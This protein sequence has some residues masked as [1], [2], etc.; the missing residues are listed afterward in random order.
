M[1]EKR[2]NRS[3]ENRNSQERPKSWAPPASLPE[4]KKL[5]GFEYRWVRTLL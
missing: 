3:H 4:P 2:I 1:A 5:A